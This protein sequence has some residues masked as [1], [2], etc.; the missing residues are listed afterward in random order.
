MAHQDEGV[1]ACPW[2]RRRIKWHWLPF[3]KEEKK[4]Q[5]ALAAIYQGRPE[6][7]LFLVSE[8][9]TAKATWEALNIMHMGAECVKDAKVQTLKAKF[10]GCA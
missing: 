1:H 6:D 9:E 2:R 3:T 4:D 8:K 5:M 10:E 7:M